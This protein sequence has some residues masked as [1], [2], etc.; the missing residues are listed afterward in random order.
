[1]NANAK[2]DGE[3]LLELLDDLL[4][5]DL[6]RDVFAACT[7]ARWSFGHRSSDDRTSR[8]FWFMD[9]SGVDAIDRLWR[10]VKPELERIAGTSLVVVRQ[11]AN[12]HTYGLGG[13]P[14]FDDERPGTFTLLY[15]PMLSWK[16]EW[17]GET[18]FFS[19][20]GHVVAG[21]AIAPNRAVFFDSRMSHAGR[22]PDRDCPELRV[23][24]ALKLIA[25]TNA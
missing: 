19:A 23:T 25:A 9:L 6:H 4:P 21:V 10:E 5:D 18:L 2:A 8:P 1:M 11:Y 22:A 7:E 13:R 20:A 14:H 17:E 3:P 15:Y 16:P 24:V 12:G